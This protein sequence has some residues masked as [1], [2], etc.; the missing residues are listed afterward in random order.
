MALVIVVNTGPGK[1]L[2]PAGTK[3][4][5][6][7]VFYLSPVEFVGIP[8]TTILL[9]ALKILIHKISFRIALL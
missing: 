1:G 2:L 6:D 4:L 5:P 7:Q 9:E 3:P 8:M